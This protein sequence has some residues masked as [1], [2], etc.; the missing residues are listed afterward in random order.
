MMFSRLIVKHRVLILILAVA[1]LVPSVLGMAATR[2]NYDLLTYLPGDIDT[3]VGQDELLSEFGKGA[4]SFVIIE[5][6]SNEDVAKLR[7]R[8]EEMAW[9]SFMT[10]QPT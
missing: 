3:M 5:G 9:N 1:L 2:V 7:D 10:A 8:I 6:M 4:F